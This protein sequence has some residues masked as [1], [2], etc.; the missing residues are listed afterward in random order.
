[1]IRADGNRGLVPKSYVLIKEEE[2]D[3]DAFSLAGR[4]SAVGQQT[5]AQGAADYN[6]FLE[7]CGC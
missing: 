5:Q 6:S 2:E 3:S 1:M 4:S 7:R